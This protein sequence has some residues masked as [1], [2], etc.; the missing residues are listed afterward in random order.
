MDDKDM[1]EVESRPGLAELVYGIL[2]TPSATFRRV[3]DDPPLFHG[4]IIFLTVTIL[5]SL[6]A[7][8]IPPD[9]S[10][11]PEFADAYAK[12]RP[13][14]GIMGALLAFIFWF[15][16]AGVLQV[17]AEFFEGQGRAIGV[18]T[19]LAL[20]DIPRVLVI[21]FQIIS[22]FSAGSFFGS[23]LTVMASLI[24]LVW[25]L[26]LSVI[27]IREIQRFSTGK[28]VVTLLTPLAVIIIVIVLITIALVGFITPFIQ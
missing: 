23:F 3:A 20:A 22:Y 18:L 7:S 1:M 13:F 26:V 24:A 4:F 5:T 19:V 2:F 21:P 16:Q 8:L 15:I 28:A 11:P 17:I 25:W 10:I 27:G 6:T 9:V 14:M 12:V